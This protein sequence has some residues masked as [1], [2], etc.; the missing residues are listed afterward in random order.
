MNLH[1]HKHSEGFQRPINWLKALFKYKEH[2]FII[3]KILVNNE[4]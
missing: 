1:F 3:V 2:I 4:N